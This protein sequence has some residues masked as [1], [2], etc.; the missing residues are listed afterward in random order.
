MTRD[1]IETF[2]MAEFPQVFSTHEIAV[3]EAAAGRAAITLR[4]GEVH[5]RPGAVISGPTIMMLADAAAYV[6]LL[7][8]GPAA[9]MAVTTNLNM[10]FL[11]AGRLGGEI[12]QSAEVLKPGRRLSVILAE[13]RD[14]AGNILA[15]ATMTYAMPE[16]AT[17]R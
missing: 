1:E 12:V 13:T 7:S 9:K 14:G 3:V 4:P 10:S 5:L 2:L 17:P 16:A 6:A 8:L 11:R 15:H